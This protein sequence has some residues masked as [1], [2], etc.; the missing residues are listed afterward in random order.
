MNPE[1]LAELERLHVKGIDCLMVHLTEMDCVRLL[2]DAKKLAEI[3]YSEPNIREMY[4]RMLP[5]ETIEQ[6]IDHLMYWRAKSE[7][8]R[9]EAE[10]DKQVKHWRARCAGLSKKLSAVRSAAVEFMKS[11][12]FDYE[13][14]QTVLHNKLA[15]VNALCRANN[16]PG[17]NMERQRMAG[18]VLKLIGGD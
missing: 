14:G 3:E 5:K 2:A 4:R 9:V 17:V 11:R 8:L 12:R 13:A 7:G 15:A 18:E 16:H 1:R 10:A 6:H